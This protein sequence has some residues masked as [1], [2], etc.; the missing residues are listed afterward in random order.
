[1]SQ[2]ESFAK[3]KE[4]LDANAQQ[5]ATAEALILEA[6]KYQNE[7]T[8]PNTVAVQTDVTG[9]VA[10]LKPGQAADSAIAVQYREREEKSNGRAPARYTWPSATASPQV[11]ESV[12]RQRQNGRLT[13][14][15]W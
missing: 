4:M 2:A 9:L 3:L 13:A 7:V 1:M 10:Q 12:V 11:T 5:Q 8:I 15:R 6:D 14:K